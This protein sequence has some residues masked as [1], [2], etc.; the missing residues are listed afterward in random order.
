MNPGWGGAL[1]ET[2]RRAGW[3]PC[4]VFAAHLLAVGV[5]AGYE[6]FPPLDVP[7]HL[8]GGAAIA[9]FFGT[10]YR[11]ARSRGLLGQPAAGLCFVLV[12]ALAA[13]A[14]V[15]WEF[16]EL[17]S[18]RFFG[19]RTQLGLED[20]L[21]D[22]LLGCIGSVVYLMTWGRDG[23]AIPSGGRSHRGV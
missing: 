11:A 21:L 17:L 20:T 19:T 15:F 12:F 22:M 18:D 14:A 2:L 13:S 8:L 16:A 4:L 6:R 3:A 5:F 23:R 9:F 1:A 7:M 10:G